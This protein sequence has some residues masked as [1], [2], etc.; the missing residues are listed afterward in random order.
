M[1]SAWGGSWG[2]AWGNSWGSLGQEPEPEVPQVGGYAG[3]GGLSG[4]RRRL[5]KQI[6]DEDEM[7]VCVV[8]AFLQRMVDD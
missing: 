2:K 4:K 5:L 1:A 8:S 3:G 6:A 7:V